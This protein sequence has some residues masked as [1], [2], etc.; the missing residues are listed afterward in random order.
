V[1]TFAGKKYGEF[2][3]SWRSCNANWKLGILQVCAPREVFH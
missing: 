2:V 1:K 3:G